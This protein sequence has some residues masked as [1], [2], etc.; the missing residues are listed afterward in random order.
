MIGELAVVAQGDVLLLPVLVEGVVR[1][2]VQVALLDGNG[3]PAAQ[4][5]SAVAVLGFVLVALLLV[6]LL[7]RRRSEQVGPPARLSRRRRRRAGRWQVLSVLILARNGERV[8]RG[9][10]RAAQ[11]RQTLGRSQGVAGL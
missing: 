1:A 5:A 10:R 3:P 2:L 9:G 4:L 7:G 8:D 11:Q 6:L